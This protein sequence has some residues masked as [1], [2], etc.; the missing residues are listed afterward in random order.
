ML[1]RVLFQLHVCKTLI[2]ISMISD[3]QNTFIPILEKKSLNSLAIFT[4]YFFISTPIY[5]KRIGNA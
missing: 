1:H 4:F 3:G 2:T 5:I